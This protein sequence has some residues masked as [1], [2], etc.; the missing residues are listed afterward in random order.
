MKRTYVLIAVLALSVMMLSSIALAAAES[1]TP[2]LEIKAKGTV[3]IFSTDA[4]GD[5]VRDFNGNNIK[6]STIV[7]YVY[8]NDFN[9]H[10]LKPIM[11]ITTKNFVMLIF[12]PKTI[13]ALPDCSNGVSG[14]EGLLKNGDDFIASGPGFTWANIH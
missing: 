6:K 13:R 9:Y 10:Q 11:I 12:C 2:L 1:Y 8:D 3:W 4:D 14:V 5:G 7:A